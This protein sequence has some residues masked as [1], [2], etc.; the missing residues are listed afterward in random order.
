M[1]KLYCY[2]FCLFIL[3]YINFSYS[4][5]NRGE[6][7]RPNILF[8]ISDDHAYQEIGVYGSKIAKTPNI[9]RI[10]KE[11]AIF[12]NS[13]VTNSICGPSRATLLTGKYSHL[14]GYKANEG[15]FVDQPTFPKVLQQSNYQTAWIGK[16]HLGSLP[17]GFN[18]FNILPG[19][20]QYYNPD[21]IENGDTTRIEGYVTNVITKL[22]TD[23]LDKRDKT[24]PFCLVVGEKATHREWLPDIQDLGAFDNVEFPLPSTFFDDYKGRVA[25][26]NNDMTV[27][28]TML[29]KEDLKIHNDNTTGVY[30]RLTGNQKKAYEDYYGKITKE[31]DE[32]HLSGEG[33][34]KW[35]Y[36]RYMRDY[37]SVA[38]SLDRNI[39]QIL[40][41]LDNKGLA[42]NTVVI[43]VS[44][45][46]FYMGEHG[47]F[48]KRW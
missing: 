17:K 25:A 7:N 33:L 5:T 19:Q 8:I 4:Q 47:W 48:D 14:N 12:R 37:L 31:F 2:F 18:Y 36:Q 23:W 43:Y 30:R 24:K 28:K 16:M 11:G 42:K 39:G 15:K 13:F 34:A 27:Y 20:G 22:T 38:K 40:D 32:K 29:L 21:F 1:K 3:S 45:Q 35:K 10:A 44:D 6:S 46:G 9:D 41:Y 26:A